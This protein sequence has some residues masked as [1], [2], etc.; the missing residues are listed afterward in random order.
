MEVMEDGNL[1]DKVHILIQRD[2]E[3]Y[4]VHIQFVNYYGCQH[5]FKEIFFHT[6]IA[7]EFKIT[8]VARKKCHCRIW[9]I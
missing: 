7:S 9:V 5:S 6:V 2:M 8:N 1:M 3:Y 4:T